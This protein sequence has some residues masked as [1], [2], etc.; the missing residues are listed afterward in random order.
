M[1]SEVQFGT[2]DMGVLLDLINFAEERYGGNAEV[3]S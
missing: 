2:L 1:I 3:N